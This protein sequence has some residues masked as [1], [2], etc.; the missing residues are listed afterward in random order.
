MRA[1]RVYACVAVAAAAGYVAGWLMSPGGGVY[2]AE[3]VP[4][5]SGS[6]ESV[7]TAAYETCAEY[8]GSGEFDRC[9]RDICR[10]LPKYDEYER[11]WRQADYVGET[12]RLRG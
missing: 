12:A 8:H 5:I 9:V 7:G 3:D 4:A 6:P 11:C 10:D 1:G 2:M